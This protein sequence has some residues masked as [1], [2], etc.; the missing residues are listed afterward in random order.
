VG[1]KEQWARRS[2]GREGAV[3]AKQQ[4][5]A[6]A[7]FHQDYNVLDYTPSTSIMGQPCG[8]LCVRLWTRRFGHDLPLLDGLDAALV[9]RNATTK[10]V[11]ACPER[12]SQSMCTYSTSL[13]NF[14]AVLVSVVFNL[15]ESCRVASALL[16]K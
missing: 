2:S 15:G 4:R 10:I 9:G 7:M 6:A 1:A 13:N 14:S 3:G 12:Y 8:L 16:I 11:I 5:G